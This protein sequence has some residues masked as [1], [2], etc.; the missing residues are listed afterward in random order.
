M[1]PRQTRAKTREA[2]PRDVMEVHVQPE[3]DIPDPPSLHLAMPNGLRFRVPMLFHD[4]SR[5]YDRS[6]ASS[7]AKRKAAGAP[8]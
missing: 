2:K 8:A 1:T 3:Q 6:M 5:R 4:V 7:L